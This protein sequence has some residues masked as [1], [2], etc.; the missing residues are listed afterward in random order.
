MNDRIPIYLWA[1]CVYICVVANFF[2]IVIVNLFSC[3]K[4]KLIWGVFYASLDKMFISSQT[5]LIK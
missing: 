3:F 5:L 1:L 2:V 4:E